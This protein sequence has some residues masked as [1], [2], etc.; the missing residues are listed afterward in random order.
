[1]MAQVATTI[2]L[3]TLRELA[4]FRAER[5]CAI[6]VFLNLDPADSPT[7]V[8]VAT[9]VGSV[10]NAVHR[11]LP[12]G[13]DHERRQG[14]RSDLDRLERFFVDGEFDRDGAAGYALFVDG[15][16]DIW[17]ALPLIAPVQDGARVGEEF[18]LAPLVPQLGRGEGA[19]VVVVNRER[20]SLY[21]LHGGRLLELVDLSEEA[22]RRHDQGGWSQSRFQRH[23]DKTAQDHYRAIA[24]VLARQFRKLGRPRIVGVGHDD[25]RAEFEDVVDA[26]VAEAIV[27]WAQ[28]EAH[29]TAPQ[30]AQVAAPLLDGWYLACEDELVDRWVERVG[31]GA[32]A[33]AG[34]PDTLDAV[35]DARVEMLLYRERANH[36]AV[37]CPR[38][39]RVQAD[40]ETCPLDGEVM[41]PAADGF[42]LAA[43]QTL[44]YGG[45][46]WD[47]RSRPELDPVEGIGAI[48]R[49]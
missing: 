13:L 11:Q 12:D 15:P 22:P 48:L 31:R 39:G 42:E 46:L 16:D 32:H 6:S 5:G 23:V 30:L 33:A 40:G 34:W 26:D 47:V 28:A 10:L 20:G 44:A 36:S 17:Q 21:R 7:A 45:S 25:A 1:M 38:C 29:A 35:S 37:R 3:D 41:Q 24:E 14:A 43:R 19:L 49:F 4:A 8:D 18:H 9:R 2:S 27:G